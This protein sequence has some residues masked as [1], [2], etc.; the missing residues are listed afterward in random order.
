MTGIKRIAPPTWRG[1]TQG[2]EANLQPRSV[3]LVPSKDDPSSRLR[4][5]LLLQSKSTEQIPVVAGT[6]PRVMDARGLQVRGR[7]KTFRSWLNR[8]PTHHDQHYPGRYGAD[9][10]DIR[11]V[12]VV[13]L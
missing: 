7:K 10:G 1:Y 2:L 5:V 9:A 6:R 12:Y 4:W 3:T 11:N 13:S 8:A